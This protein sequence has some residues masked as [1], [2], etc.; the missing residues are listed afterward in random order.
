MIVLT[1]ELTPQT[2]NFIPR[3]S[4]F[5]L[6]QITD[7]LTNKTVVIDTYTFTEGD[8]YSTLESEFNLVEN[9]FYILTIKD[10]DQTIYKDK[11]F[12][13]NQ[14]LVTFSVNN[15]QYVSNSTTNEFIVYE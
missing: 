15:G 4:D 11:I 7:E 12:C 5:D 13:T 9:R 14:S 10:G 3:S 2:F 1:T 6:V 8:Y